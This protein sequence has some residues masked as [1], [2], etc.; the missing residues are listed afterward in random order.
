MSNAQISIIGSG[1]VGLY[2]GGRLAEH[3]FSV[4]FLARTGFEALQ[5]KG[6]AVQSWQGDFAIPPEQINVFSEPSQMPVSDVVIV[7]LKST[8]QKEYA[9]I[10]KQVNIKLG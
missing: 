1:A 2:Y 9:R 7:C 6:L 10:V 5:T 8:A 4:N 3:G